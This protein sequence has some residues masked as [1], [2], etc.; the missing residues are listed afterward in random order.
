MI[1][2]ILSLALIL[3]WS[4]SGTKALAQSAYSDSE[5]RNGETSE[6]A[7]IRELRGQEITQI[8]IA[9]GRRAPENRRA[10]LYLRLAELDLEGYRAEFLLEGRV[11]E[12]RI[13][14]GQESPQ[15]DRSHSRTFLAAGI[16]A[17]KEILAL[18]IAYARL[19]QV[20][21][22]LAY[23]SAELGNREESLRYFEHLIQKFPQSAYVSDGYRELGDSAF[24]AGDFQKAKSFFE[25]AAKGATPEQKPRILHKLAWVFYRLRQPDRAVI[26]LKEA[27]EIASKGGEKFLSLK[28]EALR[29]MAIFMTEDGK[30]QDALAYFN[31]T[32]GDKTFF[33]KLL[34]RLGKQYE[35]NVQPEKATEVY[36]TLLKTHPGSDAAFRVVAKLIDL[37]L[38]R[39]RNN[40]ALTRLQKLTI[41][42]S[43]DTET[44]TAAQNLRAMIRRTA[45]EHHDEFRRKSNREAL[46]VS[47]AYYTAYLGVFLSVEDSRKETPEIQMYL[48]EVKRE[49]GKLPEA[50][51]LYRKVVDSRDQ[52]YAKEAAALWTASLADAIQKQTAGNGT[53]TAKVSDPSDLEKQF[54][55]ATDT[56]QTSLGD[57]SEGRDSALKAAQVL[58]GYSGSQKEAVKRLKAIIDRTPKSSQALMA[59]RLWLQVYSDQVPTVASMA[60][61]TDPVKLAV[62]GLKEAVKE[63]SENSAL[64]ANDQKNSGGKLKLFVSDLGQ[65]LKIGL[66]AR[67]EHGKDF[68]EAAKGYEAL[69]LETAAKDVSEKAFASSLI[70]FQK[71]GLAVD[72]ERVS[73]EWLKRFPKSPKALESIR[74]SATGWFI[75]GSM[76]TSARLFEKLGREG[77]TPESLETA[78]R[79]Y[80]GEGEFA[81]SQLTREAFLSIHAKSPLR[82]SVA[83][84]LARSYASTDKENEAKRIYKFCLT[85]P[86]E[87][88]AECA[89]RLGDL[90]AKSG[91]TVQAKGM[92][93]KAAGLVTSGSSGQK[94]KAES[95]SPFVGYARFRLAEMMEGESHFESLQLPET[96]LKKAL[97]QRMWFLE[98]LTKAY[99]AA[100]EVGGPW[101]IAG[102]HRLGLWAYNFAEEIDRIPP[103]ASVTPGTDLVAFQAQFKKNLEA[104]SVPLRTKAF[105]TWS[106]AYSKAV[107]LEI[108]SPALPEILD[109]LADARIASV[110]GV[111]AL[112]RAQGVR[113]KF[114]IAGTPPDGGPPVVEKT[115]EKLLK[116][117][118]DAEAWVDYGNLLWG[119]GKPILGRIA[120]DRAMALAPKNVLAI[121]N[122]AVMTLASEG[123]ENWAAAEAANYGFSQALRLKDDFLPAL[124][125][126]AQLLGYFRLYVKAKPL[127]E[128]AAKEAAKGA[129]DTPEVKVGLA[130]CFQGMG[131]TTANE[132]IRAL[133]S[134]A[135]GRF[136]RSYHEAALVANAGAEGAG[137]CLEGLKELDELKLV[138]FE[139]DSTERLRKGCGV[140]KDK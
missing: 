81:K 44:L 4:V 6:E 73:G 112:G 13:E 106:E 87:V 116:N 71:A 38:R 62:E 136:A 22:F 36:E 12:K 137:K 53:K 96:Q 134:D 58:A 89:S 100:V 52:R 48:A 64:L 16:R 41:P 88:D 77:G 26:A 15:I 61:D 133:G 91:E 108:L 79:I 20:Y 82:W 93:K 94:G 31:T 140:W 21:Y 43:G 28:E 97:D 118:E 34:E 5:I 123:E 69:G 85:G 126:R 67:Q 110:A 59:A 132:G 119:Q 125:N 29:D 55:E 83:L 139:K 56:L 7:K 25:A 122:R 9:L 109:G 99:T 39:G 78:A 72:T 76:L 101:G 120:Y 121:N 117:P 54:V 51:D 17:C 95:F 8:R 30:V 57:T 19:D 60:A 66:I 128:K 3:G 115:R 80:E 138:G 47:E 1:I 45:T 114:R 124:I 74:T 27:V 50:S 11:H 2:K 130:V 131:G 127:F 70:S 18:E 75:A 65:R 98:P 113:G 37:D 135:A 10:D 24:Q 103:P 111:G 92:Y 32:S 104:L 105:S 129:G 14:K 90:L 102:L 40:D 49:L 107:V 84:T 68:G 33:P 23:N 86:A 35:R 63:V 42:K 46:V